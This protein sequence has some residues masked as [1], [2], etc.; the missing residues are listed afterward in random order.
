VEIK[1]RNGRNRQ[2]V[3]FRSVD[4]AVMRPLSRIWPYSLLTIGVLACAVLLIVE[5]PGDTLPRWYLVIAA[6]GT[7]M[8][9]VGV[10]HAPRS[11][12]RIWVAIAIGQV[13]YLLGDVLW[14]VYESVLHTAPYPSPADAAYL[15]RYV[16]L[17]AG[18]I[19]LA[20]GRR[21][22]LDHAAFLDA[23][24]VS[25]AL[26]LLATIFLIIPAARGQGVS[27][28]SRV[29]AAA[30]PVGDLL[31]L[32]VLVQLLTFRALRNMAFLALFSGLS[33]LLA[34]DV[35]YTEVV[36]TGGTLPP[37]S[38]VAYLLPY[39]LI[40]FAAM[41]P[42]S[43][44]LVEAAPRSQRRPR[45]RGVLVLGGASLLGPILVAVLPL[46]HLEHD[47]VS[48]AIGSA[49]ISILVLA[50]L[51]DLL[52]VGE[53]QSDLLNVL[54]RTDSLTSLANRR[55]WDHE[56]SRATAAAKADG[57]PLTVAVIDLDHFKRYNDEHGHLAGDRV[58]RETAAAWAACLDGRGFL[59]R[60][61]GE[62]F[63]VLIPHA[64]PDA[65]APLLEMLRQC[66]AA[67]QTC[68]IGATEW[69][70]DE[71]PEHATERADGALYAAKRAGRD[72]VA[73]EDREGV[74]FVSATSVR[75]VRRDITPVFQ[76][77]VNA[78][79]GA[80]VG[81]EA[82][83]RFTD[84]T[85]LQAF[86]W[87]RHNGTTALLETAAIKAALQ[88]HSTPGWLSLNVSLS[89]LLD[90]HIGEILP[91]DLTGIVFEIT[92]YER[93]EDNP[94]AD[95]Q[96]AVLRSRGARIAIDDFG[97]GFSNLTQLL[98]LEPEIIKLDISVVRGVH[99]RPA[100]LAMIRA[101]GVYAESSGAQLC[102]E[103]V[104]TA[105]E[106]HALAEAGVALAQGYLFGHPAPATTVR[107]L[108]NG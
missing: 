69:R 87:A 70:H 16:A 86:A 44:A 48:L 10:R 104:E 55:T 95:H 71:L 84:V 91:E 7:G 59:A 27:P 62:E 23:A 11:R 20:H 92:E 6:L 72:R 90:P 30:Y 41:H 19:W 50:R 63:T 77:I 33:L 26:A 97:V 31:V 60:Y 67:E 74:W 108:V 98:W 8:S 99:K 18:L 36:S 34:V 40:G 81:H 80:T 83:S 51:L 21:P 106:W 22:N 37:W 17:L 103:G 73:V 101:L 12:R 29:V 102:A 78:Q 13:L 47:P 93:Y 1:P 105:E 25:S 35:V 79:S 65:A 46:T 54:A 75:Q 88:G 5:T 42:S 64:S 82:L 43:A 56:L 49:V 38:V 76:P 45:R 9:I 28:L 89:T 4:A 53:V 68:S 24:I 96:L 58:L 2:Q 61:G 15:L 39:L 66:V 57:T 3:F 100:H 52:R 94:T 14:Y 32:A 107:Q 85:P